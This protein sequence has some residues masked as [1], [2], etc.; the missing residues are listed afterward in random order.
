MRNNQS[1]SEFLEYL[2][3]TDLEGPNH[4]PSLQELS[5]ELGISV[6]RLRE[7][8]EVA[9]ALGLVE[10]RPRTGIRR[11]PYTFLPAVRQSLRYAIDLDRST[12][13]HYSDLRNHLEASYWHQA[14]R[15]LSAE[16]LDTLQGLVAQAWAKLRGTPI[17]IPHKEH[18]Q[19]HLTIFGRLENPFVLGILEAFWEAYEARGL[20]L[21]ADYR[22][23]ENVW[24]FHQRMVDAIC[25][26]DYDTGYEALIEHKD[27]L[28]HRSPITE[29]IK[30]ARAGSLE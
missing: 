15:C 10:V 24:V 13:A 18:R 25:N 20:N 5:R 4:L 19:L 12:F 26:K 30:K 9:R 21:Y 16:D 8:L 3:Q 17:R 6:S 27:L 22:Y 29:D 7:Q 11:L 1:Q 28:Y 14:V 2:A 23:L